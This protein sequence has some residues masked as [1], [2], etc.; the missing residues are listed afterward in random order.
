MHIRL[1]S[2]LV[3]LLS[4][5]V[6]SVSRRWTIDKKSRWQRLNIECIT[7]TYTFY[8][9]VHHAG[10]QLPQPQTGIS[11]LLIYVFHNCN[12]NFVFIDRQNE[13]ERARQ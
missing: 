10:M 11:T 2:K 3:R 7:V 8:K 12:E 5:F 9:Y 4:P 1:Y 13:T 6:C